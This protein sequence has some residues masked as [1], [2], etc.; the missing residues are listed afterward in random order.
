MVGVNQQGHL[1]VGGQKPVTLSTTSRFA[2]GTLRLTYQSQEVVMLE[3]PGKQV[4]KLTAA[5]LPTQVETSVAEGVGSFRFQIPAG[6]DFQIKSL[7]YLPTGSKPIF[8][9]KSLEGWELYQGDPKR[10]LSKFSVTPDGELRVVNGPGDLRTKAQY[11]N[12][13]LQLQCKTNGTALNSGIFFRCIAGQYQNGY[14]CQIQNGFKDNDRTKPSDFGTGA[15]YRRLAARKVVA[16][17]REWFTLTLV[18]DG[19]TFATWVNGYP[20][21]LWKDER[22]PD[23]NPRKGL[24]LAAGHLSIQGHDP[25]TDILF[26]NLRIQQWPSAK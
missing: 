16:N 18:A 23:E 19:P 10:E 2:P 26:R 5:A 9:G 20:V 14:E 15:I 8:D 17:D 25:T 6:A 12:F 7:E 1:A 3:L 11:D 13:T 24:R 21:L 4:V 22:A